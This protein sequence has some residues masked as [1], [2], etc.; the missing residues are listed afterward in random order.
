MDLPIDFA[1]GD[2][3]VPVIAQDDASGNVLMLA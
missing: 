3:L 1:K 2:G